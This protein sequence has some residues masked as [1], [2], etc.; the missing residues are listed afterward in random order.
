MA[1][2]VLGCMRLSVVLL[3]AGSLVAPAQG[4]GLEA[5]HCS[6]GSATVPASQKKAFKEFQQ[7]V[8]SGPF[9]GE[10]VSKTG[11]PTAC[12]VTLQNGNIRLV[13]LF[14]QQGRLQATTN[15]DIEFSEQ[16]V[17][18]PSL[19]E[20]KALTLLK[21]GE[22]DFFGQDGCG[23]NWTE[24]SKEKT[25]SGVPEV[26]YR[27]DTCNCQAHEV[28]KGSLVTELILRGAC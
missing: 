27:G 23:I 5:G 17:K 4:I 26:V 12:S 22:K 28:Y 19:T 7:R 14:H 15:P 8:E 10:L 20:D 16:K 24:P 11:K 1:C 21:A 25:E 13:Y 3:F 2:S 6:T 18:L 9:Y